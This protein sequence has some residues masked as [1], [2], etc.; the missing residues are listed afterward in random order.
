MNKITTT[1]AF[2]L[3]VISLHAQQSPF[4]VERMITDFWGVTF[5]GENILCYGDYG[6]ITYSLNSGKTWQQV[7][8]GDKFDILK[9]AAVGKDFFGATR[10]SLIKSTTNGL[11]WV[12]KE[13]FV[14]P[15]IIDVAIF[16][17]SI[18]VLTQSGVYVADF[19]L[20]ITSEPL[21]ALD[22]SAEYSELAADGS[23]MY[24][25]YNKKNIIHY[26]FT[27]KQYDTTNIIQVAAPSCVNC[28]NLSTLRLSGKTTYISINFVVNGPYKDSSQSIA[29]SDNQGKTWESIT[30]S[31][32]TNGCYTIDNDKFYVINPTSISSSDNPLL[33]I[34]YFTFDTSKYV[35]TSKDY[36]VINQDSTTGRM[37]YYSNNNP[38][39]FNEIIRING[40][41]LIAVGNKKMIIMSANNGKTW[42]MKSYYN[43]NFS[44][45]DYS[46]FQ[47]NGVIYIIN[48]QICYSTT[49]DGVT[50]LPQKYAYYPQFKGIGNSVHNYYFNS[51]GKG[52][53][54]LAT[55][56]TSDTNILVTNDYGN[57]FT[58]QFSDSITKSQ[59]DNQLRPRFPN[60]IRSEN[61][62]LYI[63]S[64]GVKD[65]Q[66]VLSY[67]NVVLRYDTNFRI[68]DTVI[69]DCKV[70]ISMAITKDS[71]II[72]LA[73]NSKGNNKTD[74]SGNMNDYSY[75]Y[76]LLR[77]TDNGKSWDSVEIDVPIYQTLTQSGTSDIYY[78]LNGVNSNFTAQKGPYIF[79][80]TYSKLYTK[81]GFNIIY[82]YNYVDNV[83]DSLFIPAQSNGKPNTFFGFD[84]RMY[85]AT[86]SNN[87]LYTKDIQARTPV[88]DSVK[89]GDV[90]SK[91][92]GYDASIPLINKDILFSSYMNS[93]TSGYLLLGTSQDGIA[94]I[95]FRSNPTKLLKIS[96][97]NNVE[98]SKIEVEKAYLWNFNP[99]PIPGR[100]LIRTPIFW[101]RYYSIDKA[102]FD[103][104]NMFGIPLQSSNITIYK[105]QDYSGILNWDC[106]DVPPGVYVIQIIHAGESHSFRVMVWK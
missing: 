46:S 106:S 36:S 99:Y 92:D 97:V 70:I 12:N 3:V 82:R 68:I 29:Q 55:R 33:G 72:C 98:E 17:E 73:L 21:I 11:S 24:I 65:A 7:N 13:V 20:N 32:I 102:T 15:S 79:Y 22:S 48:D 76:Y 87:L 39:K 77:S 60:A 66:G 9:I 10:S 6:I 49:N 14:M 26:S 56:N 52:F 85:L 67:Y 94:G 88:W 53:I 61:T 96:G 5:N 30:G 63:V 90:F 86:N 43:G 64:R 83:F 34:S 84:D 95:N 23:D 81:A 78:Y 58:L 44:E 35:G 25:I 4:K 101:N 89:G 38:T 41:T 50:W 28:T 47:G 45:T 57:T 75:K 100:N 42:D 31:I 59:I 71:G 18:Y 103:V 54:K 74:V 27:S 8:I 104:Y 105:I 69:I 19:N 1:I 91:W 62:L 2:F 40:D 80:P 51:T 16:K 37:I 93:D